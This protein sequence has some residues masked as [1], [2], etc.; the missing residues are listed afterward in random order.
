MPKRKR[1]QMEEVKDE[2][3]TSKRRRRGLM[4]DPG[5]LCQELYETIRNH[6]TDDGRLLCEAFIRVPKRRNSADYYEVV[7]NPIDL[8]KIQQKLKTEE[9][10]EVDH[11]TA[12]IEMMINNAKMYYKKNSTEYKDACQLWDL[13]IDTKNH[14]LAQNRIDPRREAFDDSIQSEKAES[15][16]EQQEDAVGLRRIIT[17]KKAEIDHSKMIPSK[18]SE[19]IR[20][21]RLAGGQTM[22]AI[23]AALQYESEGEDAIMQEEEADEDEEDAVDPDDSENPQWQLYEAVRTHQ[24][25]QGYVLSEPFL[26]LPSRRVYP[27]Y[28]KEIKNPLSLCNIRARVKSG[29]YCSVSDLVDDLNTMFDNAK[30]YNRADSRIY[31]DAV[32]LQKI[33]QIKAREL[34]NLEKEVES[35]GDSAEE[36]NTRRKSKKSPSDDK[37]RSIR[38]S[39]EPDTQTKKRMRILYK[40]LIDSIDET[41]RPLINMFMEKPSRKD[42]PDYYQV[43]CDPIDMKSIDIN[44][45]GDKYLTEEALLNDFKL[46]FSNCRQYNEEDSLIYRDADT[47]EQLLTTKVKELDLHRGKLTIRKRKLPPQ[48]LQ[49]LRVL[50][51]TVKDYTDNK[52]RKLSSIFM[53]LPSKNDYRDYYEVIK[54]PLDMQ[55]IQSKL[56]SN[57]YENLDELLSDFVLVFDNACKYNEPDSQIYKDALT[58]Q[59]IVLQTKLELSETEEGVPDVQALVQE[60]LTSLFISVYNH[61]DEEGRCYSDSLVE[62]CESTETTNGEKMLNLDCIKRNLDKGRYKR[63]DRFQEDM[64]DVFEK[65]RRLSRTDSQVFEDSVE[66]QSYFIKCRDDLCKRGEV[67][68]SPALNYTEPDL[69]LN[70]ENLRREKLPREQNDEDKD[71]EQDKYEKEQRAS[72]HNSESV[73]YREQ[74]YHVGDFVYIEPREK[75]LEPHI[76]HI[77]KL[78]KDDQ[79][80]QWLFGCWF[81]RPNETFHLATRKFL[82]K[83]VFKSDNYNSTRM[84]QV[85]GKCYVMFVKDY[86]K[87]KPAGVPDKDVYVCESRYSAK[88]KAFKKIKIWPVV[89]NHPVRFVPR[90]QVLTPIRVPSVFKERVERIKE[91]SSDLDDFDCRIVEK[92]KPDVEVEGQ[93]G[94]D[95]IVYFEQRNIPTGCYKLGDT[96]YV[97]SDTGKQLIARIDKMWIDKH[98][99]GYFHGPWFVT[100]VEIQHPPTRLFYKQEVFLSSIEDTNPLLSVSGRCCVLEPKDYTQYR[101]TEILEQDFY[102]CESRYLEVERQV[103]K[104]TK[105]LKKFVYSPR[106]I[107]DEIYIFRKPVMLPKNE[108]SLSV[109]GSATRMKTQNV[110]EPS[111]LLPKV[112][113][114]IE[115]EDSNDGH[116]LSVG[117]SDTP[118]PALSASSAN[119]SK[120]KPLRRLVT[121]YILFASEVRKSFIVQNPDSSFGEISRIVGTEWRNLPPSQKTEYEERAQKM[122]EE[123]AAKEAAAESIPH[124]PASGESVYECAWDNCDFQF[125]DQQDFIE[126]LIQETSGHVYRSYQHLLSKENEGDSKG[127]GQFQCMWHGCSRIRKNVAPFPNIQRLIRHCKEV[128][129]KSCN[130]NMTTAVKTKNFVPS[131]NSAATSSASSSRPLTPSGQVLPN[132]FGAVQVPLQ[133]T[134]DPLFLAPPPKTQRLL[135]SEAYIRYIEGLQPDNKSVSN[136]DSHLS[137]AQEN[138]PLSDSGRLPVHWLGNGVG[139]H[140]NVVNALWALRDFMMKDALNIAKVV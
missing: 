85:L 116:A 63:M 91:E 77:E 96:V 47:L 79:G 119:S 61:Q 45:K 56:Q 107:P 42:Y 55:R 37:R 25:F 129:I 124:S 38:R 118:A 122:N 83:E 123:T 134:V 20:A 29:Y 76:I 70:V 60:M 17:N 133:K 74:T 5:Q 28:Y 41:S 92:E 58:L 57:Q 67:L 127:D 115:M 69:Q 114:D 13:Y 132:A 93:T 128:H 110:S 136:W 66:L 18:T 109:H 135:H 52:N 84:N 46:M 100:P 31:K 103:R 19:R 97:R 54:K 65:A 104:L 12:D 16:H 101:S 78:W 40:T 108:F 35:D 81:Y 139:N 98:G 43:I 68:Q 22:S 126:H 89:P 95:G 125:E 14:F 32:K 73:S 2:E 140:G 75:G 21:K 137:A 102:V 10:E 3:P 4:Y 24:N 1:L 9:Y 15:E 80:E 88:A 7:L 90:D 27:D 44:I 49:K 120:K 113:S 34:I 121:G 112:L 6:K 99:N 138:T 48:L 72:Q 111:P 53:K 30:H 71:K 117:S 82:E 62:L 87:Y 23:T 26:R 33:M 130:K 131:R 50:Y 51:D 64:F 36:R 11:M 106:V 94:E 105:G 86:F 59:R 8:L 39:H